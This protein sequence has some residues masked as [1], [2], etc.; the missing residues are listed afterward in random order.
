LGSINIGLTFAEI[1]DRVP[2]PAKPELLKELREKY[3][4]H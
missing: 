4:V 2:V 3:G 1:Y